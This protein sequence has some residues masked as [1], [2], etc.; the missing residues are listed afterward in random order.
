[1]KYLRRKEINTTPAGGLKLICLLILFFGG[2]SSVPED[3]LNSAQEAL[4]R[5]RQAKADV[6]AVD[7]Y[8]QAVQ[9]LEDAEA[10]I[11]TENEK[12]F[13]SRDYSQAGTLLENAV[14]LATEAADAA[15]GNEQ[16]AREN[17]ESELADTTKAIETARKELETAPRGKGALADL[18]VLES[19]LTQAEATLQAAQQ[20][21]QSELYLEALDKLR[22]ARKEANQVSEAVQLAR[23]N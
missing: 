10:A 9:T 13:F 4:D 18:R 12:W 23:Q 20:E 17:A 6:Y 11:E 22:S 2:C 3:K 8:T 19:D 7:E 1:M 5:A 14:K 21:L 16:L 15:P